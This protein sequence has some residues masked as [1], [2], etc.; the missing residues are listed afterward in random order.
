MTIPAEVIPHQDYTGDGIQKTFPYPWRILAAND[1]VVTINDVLTTAYTVAGVNQPSGGTITFT[2]APASGALIV[3]ERHTP[4][5]QLLDYISNDNFPAESHEYGLDK[6]TILLQDTRREIDYI[7]LTPGPPGPQGPVGPQGS[8]GP[9]GATGPAGAPG[10]A[11]PEGPQG[12]QGPAGATGPK[13]DTGAP[14]PQ[15]D[16]GLVGPQGP[17]GPDGP[18]GPTGPGVPVGGTAGQVLAKIDAVDYNTQ[19]LASPPPSLAL[20]QYL[21]WGGLDTIVRRSGGGV[22]FRTAGIGSGPDSHFRFY[23]DLRAGP[24]LHSDGNSYAQAVS[25]NDGSAG[26]TSQEAYLAS[27]GRDQAMLRLARTGTPAGDWYMMFRPTDNALMINTTAVDTEYQLAISRTGNVSVLLDQWLQWGGLDTIRRT[28][29]GKI[30]FRTAGIEPG[31]ADHFTFYGGVL[32]VP[33]LHQDGNSYAQIQSRNDGTA[34]G[35]LQKAQLIAIGRD[36]AEVALRRTGTPDIDWRIMFRT[37]DNALL[38]NT[39]SVD[40]DYRLAISRTGDL[41]V[42]GAI[43]GGVFSDTRAGTVPL[44]GG[45]QANFLR[46]DGTWAAP[47]GGG[48]PTLALDQWLQWGGVDTIRRATSGV[49]TIAHGLDQ[50]VEFTGGAGQKSNVAVL[51]TGTANAYIQASAETGVPS[52]VTVRTSTPWAFGPDASNA[53]RF[54]QSWD[55]D[56]TNPVIM[57]PLNR[58]AFNVYPLLVA[59]AGLTVPSAVKGDLLAA[60][61]GGTFGRFAVGTDGQVLTADAASAAGVK[62][63]PPT[64]GGGGAPVNATYVTTT[65]NATLEAETVLAA[66]TGL[67]LAGATFSLADNGV[68]NAK[69]ADMATARFKGRVAAGTGDPEDLTGTQATTLLDTFTTTLKGLV[70]PPTAVDTTKYLRTDGTW[71]A[72]PTGGAPVLALDQWLQWGGVDTMRRKTNGDVEIDPSGI[73]WVRGTSGVDQGTAVDAGFHIAQTAGTG[74]PTLDIEATIAGAGNPQLRF[75]HTGWQQW[76]LGTRADGNF[77]VASADVAGAAALSV[78]ATGGVGVTNT[79]TVGTSGAGV[80]NAKNTVKAFALIDNTGALYPGSHFG[81]ASSTKL[82]LGKYRITYTS[83]LTQAVPMAACA[84]LG[85][86]L[87]VIAAT[88]ATTCDVWVYDLTSGVPVLQDAWIQVITVST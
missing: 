58:S 76:H 23:G 41:S 87:T 26:G 20:D 2:T 14:G 16:Q 81:C 48:A 50:W 49:V 21:T 84:A 15:G 29:A 34:G 64:G 60:A 52:I 36:Q 3:I 30:E 71:A 59:Q 24:W 70:P 19:W 37:T 83:A 39:T 54:S 4:V 32:A 9:V 75:T 6:L 56:A 33:W 66:G 5:T 77:V 47:A 79:L 82:A 10:P 8:T 11:G 86:F 22:E 12:V 55:P 38:F 68:T 85:P 57:V 40:A 67:A 13:G 78:H 42:V 43:I 31:P 51:A 61:S 63:A 69:L 27:I 7:E 35:T 62:W 74:R 72:P 17:A 45:G 73:F 25:I 53:F 18:I 88:T 28:T 1:L 65:A 44:S 80:V 46:A